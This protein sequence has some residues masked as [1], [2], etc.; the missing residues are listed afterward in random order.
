MKDNGNTVIDGDGVTL[1]PYRPEHVPHYN[2][3]MQD[4]ALQETTESEPLR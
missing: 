4:P 2:R 1:V 3:W